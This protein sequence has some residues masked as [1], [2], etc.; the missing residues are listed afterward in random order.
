MSEHRRKPPQPQGGGRAAARR[1]ARS[2]PLAAAQPRRGAPVSFRL[3]GSAA[4]SVRTAAGPRPAAP[5]SAPAAVA[6][7]RTNDGAGTEAGGGGRRGGRGGP[8]TAP[9]A[10]SGGRPPEEADHRLPAPNKYGWRA[11][12]AV[13]EAGHRACHRLLRQPDGRG[14]HRVRHGGG[15]GRRERPPRRRTTSTTGPTAARWSPRVARSTGRTSASTRSPRR[16]RTRSSR[17]RT[18]RS[19]RTRASTPWVSAAPC[20]TWPRAARPRVARPSPSST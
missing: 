12:G 8:M 10:V 20:S 18:R 1:A 3:Y 16:C 2:R 9:A 15:A 11:L 7:A 6:G 4:R 17:P 13:V 5:R 19:R 14:G